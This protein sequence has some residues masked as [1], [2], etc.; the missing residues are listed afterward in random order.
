SLRGDGDLGTQPATTSVKLGELTKLSLAAEPLTATMRLVPVPVGATVSIDAVVLGQGVWEG[1]LR[2]GG[3][4]VEVAAEGFV[5]SRQD[6]RLSKSER[7]AV[8]V[9]LERDLSSPLWRSTHPAR[10][11]V[12]ADIGP[13]LGLTYGGDVRSAC[14]GGCSPDVPFGLAVTAR[15]GY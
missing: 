4:R 14:S 3:H 8:T 6:V 15:G 5:P 1:R 13:A 11:F 7:K 2:E 10:V 9:S 12:G